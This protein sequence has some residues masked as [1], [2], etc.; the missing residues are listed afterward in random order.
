MRILRIFEQND[1][2]N[3]YLQLPDFFYLRHL[4][5][6]ERQNLTLQKRTTSKTSKIFCATYQE[7]LG[8]KLIKNKILN[9]IYSFLISIII[10]MFEK[11]H[12]NIKKTLIFSFKT[13]FLPKTISDDRKHKTDTR[14][15][16]QA[17]AHVYHLLMTSS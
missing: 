3:F 6:S 17:Q 9:K 2:R 12:K 1:L 7:F 11:S 16:A 8:L 4:R 10:L 15:F 13:C 14:I 5:S